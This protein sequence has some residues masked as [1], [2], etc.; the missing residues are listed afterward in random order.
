[1]TRKIFWKK[2]ISSLLDASSGDQGLK[3]VLG[4]GGLLLMG[5]GAIIGAGIFILTGIASANY[6]GPALILSFMIAG[7]ACLFTALCYAEFATMVP[8]AGSAYTYSYVTLG[9]IWAWIIGWDLILEYLVIVAAVS[10]GWS[11]YLVNIFMKLGLTLPSS[12]INPIGINGGIINL[13]AVL[14]IAVITGLLVRGARE[15]SN[16]NAVIV[17]VKVAVILIFL[18]IGVN[19]INPANYHP[20]MPYGWSGVFKGAA[21]IFFAYIG[22]DAITTAAEEVKKPQ[23][24]IPIAIVGSLIIS[25]M[26]YIAVAAVLNGMVPYLDFKTTA[27]PVA[28][29]LGR[30]GIHWAD[31]IVSVGALCGITSVL[32]VNMF[33]QTRIFF[34]MSRDGLLPERFSKVHKNFKTPINGII[35]V[36][37]VAS[38]LA[39]FLPLN[40]IVELVNIGTLAAFTLVSAAVIVLRRQRPDIER[41][42][43]CPLVPVV[44]AAAIVFCIFLITQLPTVTHLRFVVWL[45]IGLTVYYFYGKRKSKL[46]ANHSS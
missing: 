33:G 17:T 21:I 11:S 27:A 9:E 13:P 15:S 25:S 18:M 14:I 43:K 39:A 23:R 2:P 44:P 26:L 32:L 38:V 35:L 8:V 37:V 10:V 24:T 16:F 41:P 45:S 1:M 31:I 34:A 5:I 4:S 42:F 7:A 3:R 40:D 12:L 20:F 19:Y 46:T 6:S 29:A 22:F 28:Y 30:V 36:G